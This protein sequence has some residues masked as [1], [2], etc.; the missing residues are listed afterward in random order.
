MGKA[1]SGTTRTVIARFCSFKDKKTLLGVRKSLK[2]KESISMSDDYSTE[3]SQRR[4][5]VFPVFKAIQSKLKE[6]GEPHSEVYLKQ[7]KL[8]L[9]G[10]WYNPDELDK[11]PAG[12]SPSELSTPEKN[13]ITA[14]YSKR[15]PL[16]NHYIC[17]FKVKGETYNCLEQYLM[18][19][20]ANLFGDHQSVTAIAKEENPIIQKKIGSKIANF[21]RDVWK[22]EAGKI[23]YE[24]LC[25]KFSQNPTLCKFLLDT[26]DTVLVE[27]NPRDSFFGI[28]IG[29][30]NPAVW[31]DSS[32]K[33]SNLQGATLQKV[34]NFLRS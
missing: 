15:S 2:A 20:K 4:R 26:K 10:K 32:W 22:M 21:Q 6:L 34:R 9:K 13:G 14:F 25:A 16:S 23:L 8:S 11:L 19:Q 24:G 30:D 5:E 1:K 17:D 31:D 29:L 3:T 18:I 27:A 28:G 12:F 33:G 7:D